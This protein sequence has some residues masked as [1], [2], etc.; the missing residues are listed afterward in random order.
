MSY[1]RRP[2][3]IEQ[4]SFEIITQEMGSAIDAFDATLQPV[5]K[6]VIHT[7][8]DF[9]YTDL[10]D[11]SDDAVQS[12]FDALKSGCKI[13]CDT[14]MIVNGLSK[15]ALG[16]FSCKPY[17][18]VSDE[19]VSKEA[20]ERGVTRSIVGMEHAAKD[21]ETKIFL[22][23][24]APTAL[25]TLLEMIKSGDCA[26]PSLIVAVPVGF[27]GAAESKEEVLKYDVPYIRVR[28]RKGGSTVAVAIL[29]GLIYQIFQREGI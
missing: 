15:V 4:K 26:K 24:N 1:E 11:F 20:K 16:K 14:N 28:G 7:T 13:Y 19:D 25:Y 9:E 6:R 18:L 2:M 21:P 23:G 27:V 12:T 22:I 10:L 29:H 5:V 17:C 8:A 3:S